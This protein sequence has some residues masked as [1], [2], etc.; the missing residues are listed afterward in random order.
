MRS[1]SSKSK[2]FNVRMYECI[3]W[4][5]MIRTQLALT[6][7]YTDPCMFCNVVS[8]NLGV[9]D[10]DK[11]DGV[12]IGDIHLLKIIQTMYKKQ[13]VGYQSKNTS[14]VRD[15]EM[16]RVAG[17]LCSLDQSIAPRFGQACTQRIYLCLLLDLL[18]PS[19][20]HPQ[21]TYNTASPASTTKVA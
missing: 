10:T 5:N 18:S 19:F 4:W 9:I 3:D 1:Q 14:S 12:K 21:S 16:T 20:V 2:H 13:Q 7:C 6:S 11:Q 15:Q 8:Y 17:H